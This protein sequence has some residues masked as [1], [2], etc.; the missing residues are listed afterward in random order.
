MNF[1]QQ[2]FQHAWKSK[3]PAHSRSD[4]NLEGMSHKEGEKT[5]FRDIEWQQWQKEERQKTNRKQP[6]ESGVIWHEEK[7]LTPVNLTYH[8]NKEKTNLIS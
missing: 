4:G 7:S 5:A 1:N 2:F 3:L 8:V 6:Q